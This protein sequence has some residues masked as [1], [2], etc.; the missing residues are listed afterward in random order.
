MVLGRKKVI[1]RRVCSCQPLLWKPLGKGGPARGVSSSRD[2]PEGSSVGWVSL[3]TS[4]GLGCIC[5]HRLLCAHIHKDL[6]A[7]WGPGTTERSKGPWDMFEV[8]RQE[9]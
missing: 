4:K 7:F 2:E 8:K 6:G 5:P 3:E 9:Q 1:F